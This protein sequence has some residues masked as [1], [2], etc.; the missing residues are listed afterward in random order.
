[1]RLD[2]HLLQLRLFND[3]KVAVGWIMAGKVVVDGILV[4]KLGTSSKRL[5]AFS[6]VE[7]RCDSRAAAATSWSM[8]CSASASTWQE[9]C[10]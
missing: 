5:L 10:A 8:P 4:T 1:M 9:R 7:R 6:C 2:Y 3:R